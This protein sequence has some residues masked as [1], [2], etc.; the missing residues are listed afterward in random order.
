MPDPSPLSYTKLRRQL[1][2]ACYA[3]IVSDYQ[4]V[5]IHRYWSYRCRCWAYKA[6]KVAP[7][8]VI[9]S[10]G[11]VLASCC[12]PFSGC[13]HRVYLVGMVFKTRSINSFLSNRCTVPS[14]LPLQFISSNCYWADE[15]CMTFNP[16][17]I[18][19]TSFAI[20]ANCAVRAPGYN[21]I[22]SC[23]YCA[24]GA[25]MTFKTTKI[26]TICS[27]IHSLLFCPSHRYNDI[28]S[29][30]EWVLPGSCWS[31]YSSLQQRGG[32]S[33]ISCML[34]ALKFSTASSILSVSSVSF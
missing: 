5:T 18:F 6:P 2:D 19:P 32:V 22:I 17:R 12:N 33:G 24:Y 28:M 34:S 9:D 7:I 1:I 23:R 31:S 11:A 15:L 3:L 8:G 4:R 13:C 26:F 21:N 29:C 14:W 10:Y 16:Q 27:A 25:C 20:H 30:R